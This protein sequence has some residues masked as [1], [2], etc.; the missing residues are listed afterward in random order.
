MTK[1]ANIV[2]NIVKE[3][4]KPTKVCYLSYYQTLGLKF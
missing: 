2:E 1:Q 4:K 3:A